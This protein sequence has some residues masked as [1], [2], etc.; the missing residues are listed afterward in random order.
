MIDT[1][2]GLMQW[3]ELCKKYLLE[4]QWYH[5]GYKPSLKEFITNGWV[6]SAG[7][8]LI[9][10]AY[11]CITNP[12]KDEALDDMHTHP[13]ILK[14]TSLVSRLADDLGTSTVSTLF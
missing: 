4:A 10:H 13:E 5:S 9:E 6:S 14:W 11:F 8:L 12:L 2:L 3:A 1:Y 7:P